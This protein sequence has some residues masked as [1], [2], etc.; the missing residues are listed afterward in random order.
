MKSERS[1][2]C[3]AVR[4]FHTE[5]LYHIIF[6]ITLLCTDSYGG[7]KE[8]ETCCVDGDTGKGQGRVQEALVKAGGVEVWLCMAAGEQRGAV[9]M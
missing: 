9:G 8:R 5:V 7:S 1:S 2:L 3:S 4:Y 6:V